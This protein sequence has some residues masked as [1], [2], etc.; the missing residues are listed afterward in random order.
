MQCT[1][2]GNNVTI[3]AV[4]QNG[5]FPVPE[6]CPAGNSFGAVDCLRWSYKY[7]QAANQNISVSAVTIDSDLDIIKAT[8]GALP[9]S[10]GGMKIYTGGAS[11]SSIGQLGALAQDFRTVKFSSGSPVTGN[12]WTRT[13]VGIGTVTALAKVG[14][15]GPTTCAIAGPDNIV[16]GIGVG[17]APLT[18]TQI[19]T[20][21]DCEIAIAVDA[22]GCANDIAVTSGTC[23]VQLNG[24]GGKIRTPLIDGQP[25]TGGVCGGRFVSGNNTCLN[26]CVT[27]GG[28]CFQI[29]K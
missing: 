22:K 3:Q 13:N 8:S 21:E 20:F 14:N 23:Q 27:S 2:L 18:T 29:C 17:R 28:G 7:T 25:F 5:I 6:D 19:D 11:D 15:N 26:Y 1:A 10:T 12:I 9:G 16:T 4:A 24:Q